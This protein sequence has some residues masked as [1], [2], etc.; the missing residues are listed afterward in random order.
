MVGTR[1][2]LID[3]TPFIAT[4]TI[5]GDTVRISG[6]MSCLGIGDYGLR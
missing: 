6:L 3:H 1:E 5:A 4:Y 2:L